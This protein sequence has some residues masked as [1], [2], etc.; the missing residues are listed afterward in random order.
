MY[1]NLILIMVRG[2]YRLTCDDPTLVYY[3]SSNDIYNRQ[4]RHKCDY[5]N[6]KEN[7]T[8]YCSSSKLYEVG[9][10]KVEIVL[11]CPD[12][13]SKDEMRKIEQTYI[14]NNEC[15]NEERAYQTI[16]QRKQQIINHSK[17]LKRIEYVEKWTLENKERRKEYNRQRYLN[18]KA[19]NII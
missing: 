12:D 14:D 9:G 1:N 19:K 8:T 4:A 17:T 5:K 6:Y 7:G 2:V 13:I 15:V 11:E 18:K 3:G 16:E 10:V